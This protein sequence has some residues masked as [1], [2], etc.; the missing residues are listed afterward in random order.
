MGALFGKKK[1]PESRVT[2]QDKAIL[3]SVYNF[4]FMTGPLKMNVGGG[5]GGG[6]QCQVSRS[7]ILQ[8]RMSP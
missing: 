1:Q 7:N 4:I 8:C 5:G 3:V 6:G 2:E